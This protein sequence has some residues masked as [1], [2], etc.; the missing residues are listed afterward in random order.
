MALTNK[1]K[2]ITEQKEELR[3]RLAEKHEEI[4]LVCAK[5][6]EFVRGGAQAVALA[7]RTLGESALFD[8]PRGPRDASLSQLHTLMTQRED[9]LARL[10]GQ[11]LLREAEDAHRE[12][13]AA[14]R[15]GNLELA[16]EGAT[17]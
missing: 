13:P 7:W 4:R 5:V 9:A 16:F 8:L 14:V 6:P 1:A 3:V 17:P 15:Q 10:C 2:A 11:K 12:T